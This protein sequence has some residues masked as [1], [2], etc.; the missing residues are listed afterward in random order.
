MSDTVLVALLDGDLSTLAA[1]RDPA[2]VK[3][4]AAALLA[5]QPAVDEDGLRA[6]LELARRRI[7]ARLAGTEV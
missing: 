7:L 4:T 2:L 3:S 5:A 1:S 6:P